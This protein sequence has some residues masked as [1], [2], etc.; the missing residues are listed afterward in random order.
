MIFFIIKSVLKPIVHSCKA[1][2]H[3]QQPKSKDQGDNH[4]K[5]TLESKSGYKGKSV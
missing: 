2:K 5:T 1:T 3:A 4:K